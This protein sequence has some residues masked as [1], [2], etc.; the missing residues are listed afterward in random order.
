MVINISKVKTE[1]LLLFCRDLV[2]SYDKNDSNIFDI[3]DDIKEFID[4]RIKGIQKAINIA[5]QPID[6]YIRNAQVSRISLIVKTY[7]YINKTI[8]KR[9]RDGDMFNPSMLCIA[10]LSTW[11]AELSACEEDKE[12]IYFTIYPYSEVY[13]KLLINIQNNEFKNLNINMLNIAED[14]IVKLHNYRFK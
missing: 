8:S 3:E 13:D 12:F 5:V 6:Y 14:T 10:L 1:A 11:F 2:D 7:E 4:E 9:F